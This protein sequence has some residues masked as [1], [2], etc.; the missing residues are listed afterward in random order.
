MDLYNG[1]PGVIL[2]FAYL[3]A[4]LCDECYSDLARSAFRTLQQEI[5]H[6]RGPLS[7]GAFTGWGGI[8]YCLTHLGVLWRDSA[9]LSQ[10]EHLL[11]Q[12]PDLLR[13]D[14][15]LDI[16]GGAA[17]AILAL[18]ALHR[19]QPSDRTLS[20]ARACGE[21][22]LECSTKT[23]HGIG[24]LGNFTAA[25]PLTGFAHGNAGVAY[26]LFKVAAL[27]GMDRFSNAAVEAFAY[28]RSL[29]SSE[30]NNW[31]DLRFSNPA[32]RFVNAWCHGAP[33]IGLSRLC[34]LQHVDDPQLM[35]EIDAALST[36]LARGFGG[37]STLCHGDLGNADILLHAA[38]VLHQPDWHRYA[39]K[40][41][42]HTIETA[43]ESGWN[44]GNPLG[45]ESPGLMTGIAGIGYALLR[46]AEPERV[47]SVLALEPPRLS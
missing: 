39:N 44:C 25:C 7:V 28:E 17:G 18:H 8:I 6:P 31:P 42:A 10:A 32:P 47:P 12:I 43:A 38:E 24:W 16:I 3:G 21:H 19:C 1:L 26:A 13:E 45:V 35:I 15:Q 2:F 27:T 29:F 40:V 46:C 34:S 14:K 5:K 4:V 22:L 23:E 41:A 36:T 37:G 33:G 30:N 20:V 9:C 11:G